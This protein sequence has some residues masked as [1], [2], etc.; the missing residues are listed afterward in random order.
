MPELTLRQL[1]EVDEQAGTSLEAPEGGNR[2]Q[3]GLVSPGWL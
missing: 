1:V 2:R 3:C